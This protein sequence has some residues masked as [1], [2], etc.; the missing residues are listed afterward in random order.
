M[1]ELYNST[2]KKAELKFIQEFM[3]N[4]SVL[5]YINDQE[6]ER[7]HKCHTGLYEN[8]QVL[9]LSNNESCMSFNLRPD[10]F[11]LKN[12]ETI[13]NSQKLTV[14]VTGC[15]KDIRLVCWITK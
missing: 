12:F 14:K 13:D 11:E 10:N 8:D 1:R 5:I 15:S 3:N 7:I 9:I 2:V 6:I 4:Q